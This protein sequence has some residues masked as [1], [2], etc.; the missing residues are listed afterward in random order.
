MECYIVQHD[1]SA[2]FDRV[3]HRGILLKLKPIGVGGSVFSICKGFLSNRRQ[4]VVVDG[5]TSEYIP[6]VSGV[7][8]GSVFGPLLFILYTSVMFELLENRLYV[9][10]D[11]S[12]LLSVVRK[13]ADR[14]AVAASRNRDLARIQE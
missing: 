1:F 2:A 14:P 4:R 6:I 13:T 8:Q 5:A 10:A 3:S 12:T 11:D 9:Y 7:P